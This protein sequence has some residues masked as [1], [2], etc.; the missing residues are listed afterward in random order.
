MKYTV[1]L[2]L[3]F[4]LLSS[5]DDS[6]PDA[7]DS[8]QY[9]RSYE[10]V[11]KTIMQEASS[12]GGSR[13][14]VET[15]Y[16]WFERETTPVQYSGNGWCPNPNPGPGQGDLIPCDEGAAVVSKVRRCT[17]QMTWVCDTT[18][19]TPPDPSG[20]G[21]PPPGPITV[22]NYPVVGQSTPVTQCATGREGDIF[23]PA[24]QAGMRAFWTQSTRDDAGNPLPVNQR[25]ET[26]GIFY[27]QG[28]GSWTFRPFYDNEYT[29]R[30]N[31]DFAVSTSAPPGDFYIVHTHPYVDGQ[32]YTT[33]VGPNVIR[34]SRQEPPFG[35][36]SDDAAYFNAL[37]S[38]PS[39][40]GS[41]VM[42]EQT[43][44]V[45][46]VGTSGVQTFSR[47]GF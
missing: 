32:V 18:P 16:C 35:L 13:G 21:S 27:R 4:L 43:I 41:I 47:C 14:Y 24:N 29:I 2:P 10:L 30:N 45:K 11:N 31:S 26:A 20:G 38:N 1:Y 23:S 22:P 3:A 44:A 42:T 5:C 40:K 28:D 34:E 8:D 36:R 9:T 25:I 39:F 6:L 15:E 19:G 37:S 33:Q 17:T 12:L 46:D 7:E